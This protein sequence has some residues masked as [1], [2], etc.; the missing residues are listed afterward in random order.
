MNKCISTGTVT[1][2][3]LNQASLNF[4]PTE[5]YHEHHVLIISISTMFCLGQNKYYCI[6]HNVECPH[7]ENIKW[8][9]IPHIC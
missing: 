2:M 4:F 5:V 7:S 1:R 6:Y 9:Y 8:Q 3:E